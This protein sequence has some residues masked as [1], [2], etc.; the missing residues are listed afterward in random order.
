[1]TSLE[2]RLDAEADLMMRKLD[3]I[4]SR[5]TRENRHAPTEDSRQTTDGGG[6]RGYAGAQP[7]SRA[8]FEYNLRETQCSP[9]EGGSDESG[10]TRS[11]SDAGGTVTD[12]ATSQI[13]ARSDYHLAGHFNVEPLKRSLE[14]FIAKLSKSTERGE[15]TIRTLKK[16][17]SYRDDSDG[18]IDNWIEMMTL[19][20]D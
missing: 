4:L 9:F 8:D 14:T 6:A 15:R 10:P 11:G 5:G 1:M 18:C 17:K 13:G 2:R 7:R 20:F 12:T 3:E 16:P 19:H